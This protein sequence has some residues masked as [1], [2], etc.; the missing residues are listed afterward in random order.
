MFQNKKSKRIQLYAERTFSSKFQDTFDF[1]RENWKPLLR[2]LTY[3]LLPV[4]LVQALSFNSYMD[5]VMAIG[6]NFSDTI[7]FRMLASLSGM[8]LFGFIGGIF[9]FGVVYALMNVYRRREGGLKGITMEELKPELMKGLRRSLISMMAILVYGVLVIAVVVLLFLISPWLIF[10][11]YLAALACAL[12]LSMLLPIYL[13]EDI[14]LMDAVKKAF[15][16]GFKTW[17]GIFA[18]TFVVSIIVGI[19]SGLVGVPI[20]MMLMVKGFLASDLGTSNVSA[21]VD[22]PAYNVTLYLLGVLQTYVSHLGY[23]IVAIALAYQYGHAAEKLD[24]VSVASDIDNFEQIS[25]PEEDAAEPAAQ[26]KF[27]EI[28]EFE[29]L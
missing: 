26:R 20:Q 10:I 23:S 27:D 19:V 6:E 7:L 25:E 24:Q 1:A 22:S 4:S 21:I 5:S 29:N 16:Y 12:P 9:M 11:P 13:F 28:S 2:F 17:G 14:T 15:R 3:F 8:M 18:I